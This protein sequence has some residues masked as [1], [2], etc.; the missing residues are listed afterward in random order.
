MKPFKVGTKI[1]E[2]HEQT[3]SQN[4]ILGPSSL[5][6]FLHQYNFVNFKVSREFLN[7]S[8]KTQTTLHVLELYHGILY[9]HYRLF[10]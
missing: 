10:K 4:Q 7:Q 1:S 2:A 5:D 3:V 8:E 9:C 6:N